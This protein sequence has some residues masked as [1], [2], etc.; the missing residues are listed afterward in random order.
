[1]V[2]ILIIGIVLIG[3][4]LGAIGT[5]LFKREINKHGIKK[6]I[7]NVNAYSGA[8]LLG[9]SVIL[10]LIALRYETLTI[11]Y[12]LASTIYIWVTILSVKYLGE[13]MNKWKY[14]GLSLIII[15]TIIIGIGS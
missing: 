13:K 14:A 12:P 5:L 1:M 10:Y 7:T 3:S 6:L 15:G 11:V 4:F 9:I 2:N 8:T